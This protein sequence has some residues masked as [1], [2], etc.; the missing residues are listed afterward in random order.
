MRERVGASFKNSP[1]YFSECL[2][3]DKRLSKREQQKVF[4]GILFFGR[5]YTLETERNLQLLDKLLLWFRN[6]NEKKTLHKMVLPS[7]RLNKKRNE[8]SGGK[9]KFV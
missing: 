1:D 4:F 2:K 8:K 7:T 9:G 6:G 3:T 5:R